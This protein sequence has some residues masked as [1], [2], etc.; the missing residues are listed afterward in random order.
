[1]VQWTGYCAKQ[2]LIS[3]LYVYLQPHVTGKEIYNYSN[4]SRLENKSSVHTRCL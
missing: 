1:V 4:R 3:T 2:E